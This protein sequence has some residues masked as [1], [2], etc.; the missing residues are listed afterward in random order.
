MTDAVTASGAS[1]V[2]TRSCSTAAL[3][4]QELG[5]IATAE[6]MSLWDNDMVNSQSSSLDSRPYGAMAAWIR[7]CFSGSILSRSSFH[8]SSIRCLL[9]G[10]TTIRVPS[11]H[12]I[13]WI[14][15]GLRGANMLSTTAAEPVRT[16]IPC[17]AS[18]PI[19]TARSWARAAL[20]S[21]YFDTSSAI[22]TRPGR[23]FRIEDR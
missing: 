9:V 1:S 19:A 6:K 14:S 23:L 8:T 13:R 3:V 18:Q 17:Q 11:S 21:A 2:R 7:S 10:D 15:A 12:R 20:R 4:C 5:P 16:G 22:P